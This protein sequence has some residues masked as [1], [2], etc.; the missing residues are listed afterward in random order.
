MIWKIYEHA[1]NMTSADFLS[2][3]AEINSA[4][5]KLAAYYDRYDIWLSP[6]TARVSEPHGNYNLG[7]EDVDMDNYVEEI[8]AVPAQFTVPHNIM[9]TPAI[10]LPLAMHSSGLPIGIQLGARFANEHILLQLAAMLED[11]MPWKDRIPPI[12]V[13]HH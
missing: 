1:S 11:A 10:T 3:M 9:G 4:R 12:H 5:R 8:L 2:A 13:S 7:R 6:T